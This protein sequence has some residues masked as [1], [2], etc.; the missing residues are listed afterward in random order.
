MGKFGDSFK[1][2]MNKHFTG[3]VT[4]AHCG[5]VG[6][7]M[8][9]ATLKDG[10]RICPDCIKEIVSPFSFDAKVMDLEK[11]KE[12]YD[13]I[14][15]CRNDLAPIFNV[16]YDFSYGYFEVDPVNKLFRVGTLVHEISSI[17]AYSFV[18][19]PE[20]VKDGIFSTKVKGDVRVE[21][22]F[23]E[24]PIA[25]YTNYTIKYGAKASAKKSFLTN[26]VTYDNP[27]DME[28]FMIRFGSLWDEFNVAKKEKEL[29]DLVE[30]RA[31]ELLAQREREAV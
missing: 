6:K 23:L 1:G 18:F 27:E 28:E 7:T 3:E 15:H 12:I 20:Q 31:R 4:C 29:N 19:R 17:A 10:S 25:A 21:A 5:K 13:Y 26:T 16:D 14:Q 9:Y 8:F 2:F 11:F 30:L 22:L 24:E